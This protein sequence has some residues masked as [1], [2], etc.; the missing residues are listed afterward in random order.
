MAARGGGTAAAAY[1]S[2]SSSYSSYTNF[3]CEISC[4]FCSTTALISTPLSP[5]KNHH[6]FVN[7]HQ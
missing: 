1:E 5:L 4:A 2:L 3:K 7:G 6:L